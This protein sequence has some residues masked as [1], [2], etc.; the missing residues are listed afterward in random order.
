MKSVNK[1]FNHYFH[2]HKILQSVNLDSL[3]L[4]QFHF[5]EVNGKTKICL[6]E[7]LSK[8]IVSLLYLFSSNILLFSHSVIYCLNSFTDT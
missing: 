2:K 8:V 3:K 4:S 7:D 6:N 5:L 1:N